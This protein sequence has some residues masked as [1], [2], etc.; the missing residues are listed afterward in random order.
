MTDTGVT[1]R[2]FHTVHHLVWEAAG[3]PP[4]PP[5]HVLIFCDG[6][7][8]NFSLD[9]LELLSRSALMRRNSIH[10]YGP[11]LAR[12]SQL[13]GA[14]TQQINLLSKNKSSNEQGVSA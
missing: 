8:R 2:D 10:N 12:L 3:H 13:R 4:V 1:R 7:K 5:G 6:N 9:N 14:V 11:E